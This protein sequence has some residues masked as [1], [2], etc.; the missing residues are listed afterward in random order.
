LNSSS[1]TLN[2]STGE[3]I[4]V[5]ELYKEPTNQLISNLC[6]KMKKSYLEEAKMGYDT[7]FKK[8]L[9]RS[10]ST[11]LQIMNEKCSLSK[12]CSMFKD[13]EC[14]SGFRKRGKPSFPRCFSFEDPDASEITYQ[15]RENVYVIVV[16]DLPSLE[17]SQEVPFHLSSIPQNLFR[18]CI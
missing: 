3:S 18:I 17:F 6:T 2:L 4:E 16:F 5:V 9:G 12:S 8:F 10:P 11:C 15:W 13:K 1:Y 7:N 14:N